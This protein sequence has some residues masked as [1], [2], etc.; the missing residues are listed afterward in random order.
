MGYAHRIPDIGDPQV[1][2]NAA[3]VRLAHVTA[4]FATTNDVVLGDT[5]TY[6]LFAMDEPCVV[7]AMYTQIE[8]A[9]TASVTLDIGDTGSATRLSSDTTIDPPTTGAIFVAA[10]GLAVPYAYATAADI[11]LAVGGATVAA[12]LLNIYVQYALLRD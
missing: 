6:T 11:E 8:T 5:A 3:D 10:T 12:G 4:G 9:F 2:G 1:V 7:L